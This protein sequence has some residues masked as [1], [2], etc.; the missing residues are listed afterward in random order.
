SAPRGGGAIY[1]RVP[2]PYEG[3][4]WYR[5]SSPEAQAFIARA[6]RDGEPEEVIAQYRTKGVKRRPSEARKG[7][8]GEDAGGPR[9][10][11]GIAGA[12][13]AQATRQRTAAQ[14]TV[15]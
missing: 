12:P 2:D 9:S 14:E 3:A 15:P 10:I 11:A 7:L 4:I 13:V 6:E 5:P 8:A 1:D